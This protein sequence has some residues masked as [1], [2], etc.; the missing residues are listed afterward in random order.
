MEGLS[1]GRVRALAQAKVKRQLVGQ[2][3]GQMKGQA[4]Q[5]Q[6]SPQPRNHVAMRAQALRVARQVLGLAQAVKARHHK[7]VLSL[8]RMLHQWCS[9]FP[10]CG[11][12]PQ[13]LRPK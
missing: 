7:L 2:V 5:D 9:P 4:G 11:M 6:N 10:S 3:E 12:T 13:Q 1:E 8:R